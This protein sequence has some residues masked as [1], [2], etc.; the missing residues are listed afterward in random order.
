M[1]SDYNV[2][3]IRAKSVVLLDIDSGEILFEQDA[4]TSVL[5]ASIT[6]IMTLLL[7]YEA[8]EQGKISWSDWVTISERAAGMQSKIDLQANELVS[9]EDLTKSMVIASSNDA[10]LAIAEH[11]H[12]TERDFVAKMNEKA[13][14]LGMFNTHFLDV[15]GVA[16]S[17]LSGP[18]TTAMDVSLMSIELIKKHPKSLALTGTY[19]S[20]ITRY[21]KGGITECEFTN[22]N[23][24]LHTY[25]GITGLKTGLYIYRN[26]VRENIF[27][28]VATARRSGTNLMSVVLGASGHDIRFTESRV[29]LNY[30]FMITSATFNTPSSRNDKTIDVGI[31]ATRGITAAHTGLFEN[32]EKNNINLFW[33]VPGDVDMVSKTINGR[34][35]DKN[36]KLYRKETVYPAVID[37]CF[38]LNDTELHQELKKYCKIARLAGSTGGK[39]VMQHILEK[40]GTYRHLLIPTIGLICVE[41]IYRALDEFD[42]EIILKPS[43]GNRGIGI[44]KVKR[45]N[46]LYIVS[47]NKNTYEFDCNGFKEYYDSQLPPNNYLIQ[48]FRE[49]KTSKGEPFDIR[50]FAKRGIEGKF[51]TSIYARIGE[52][53]GVVATIR[54]G[55]YLKEELEQFLHNEFGEESLQII[56]ELEELAKTFPEYCQKFFSDKLF[57]ISLDIGIGR[58]NGRARLNL[59]EVNTMLVGARPEDPNV[60]ACF[61]YYRYLI[62][63]G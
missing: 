20:K 32:A 34:F 39:K 22:N 63:N 46:E 4:H 15:S 19:K 47:E 52:P 36:G 30:G 3:K 2:M 6:K 28:F 56:A 21:A 37:N 59:F 7:V 5:P 10:A 27:H 62:S 60:E 58:V 45:E 17:A 50:I 11:M 54:T 26:M 29:L 25:P 40:E 51:L 13:K 49:S 57:D 42:N 24:M 35:Y 23:K 48:A 43:I 53:D 41:D 44:I 1:T 33:F 16:F 8:V 18:Y 14:S 31:L 61:G 12:K 38:I 9:L 55:G